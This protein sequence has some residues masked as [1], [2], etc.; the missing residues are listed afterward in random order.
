MQTFNNQPCNHSLPLPLRW[1]LPWLIDDCCHQ[2][3][4]TCATTI[5]YSCSCSC[6]S[7]GGTVASIAPRHSSPSCFVPRAISA[8]VAFSFSTSYFYH[9]LHTQSP[10][11]ILPVPARLGPHTFLPDTGHTAE[12]W[13]AH[14]Y[15]I[16][17]RELRIENPFLKKIIFVFWTYQLLRL[18]LPGPP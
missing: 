10:S 16:M 14:L 18:K 13:L 4:P 15:D 17:K 9:F 12:L 8:P 11:C 1:P 3:A 6:S 2:P 5:S 7:G